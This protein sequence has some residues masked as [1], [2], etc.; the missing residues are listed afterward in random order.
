MTLLP[1]AGTIRRAN[2][3]T[4]PA[5]AMPGSLDCCRR[6]PLRLRIP[7]PKSLYPNDCVLLLPA[8]RVPA[9]L[10][11]ARCVLCRDIIPQRSRH[12]VS[13]RV[14]ADIRMLFPAM[15]VELHIEEAP[16]RPRTVPRRWWTW[17]RP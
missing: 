17:R 12:R 13:E 16:L 1:L 7:V 10:N 2:R 6:T 9:A 4:N 3:A 11:L 15:R 14:V 5:V 8:M